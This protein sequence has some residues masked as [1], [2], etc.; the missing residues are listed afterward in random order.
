MQLSEKSIP[1]KDAPIGA[2]CVCEL[3]YDLKLPVD[4]YWIP[5]QKFPGPGYVT[6][7]KINPK[8]QSVQEF[9]VTDAFMVYVRKE[10]L[11]D[12]EQD[13]ELHNQS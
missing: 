2:I 11:K 4:A 3:N 7:S 9:R 13:T 1:I 5:A 10:D 12:V 8:N 6:G